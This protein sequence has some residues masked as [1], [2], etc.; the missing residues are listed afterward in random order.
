MR[1]LAVVLLV[2]AC[3]GK[4]AAPAQAPKTAPPAAATQ[5]AATQAITEDEARD[6]ARELS[7]VALPCNAVTMADQFGDN[8][9]AGRLLC[10]W[11]GG[12]S[13]Y[14]LVGVR[15]VDGVPHPIMRRLLTNAD[16][17][18]MFVNYD[19]L[20]LTRGDDGALHLADVFSYRQGVWIS[21]LL[22]ANAA[23][24]PGNADFLGPSAVHPEVKAARDLLRA[25]ERSGA[26]AAIAALPE[27]V[28][29]ERPVQMLRVRAAAG[30]PAAYKA[31]LDALGTVDDPAIALT[32]LDG[33]LDRGDG[34][35]AT[36]WIDVLEK[37]IGV[38]AYLE[39]QRVVALV[40]MG[41][42]DR[43]LTTATAAVELE[44]TLTRALEIKLDVLIAKKMWP[45]VLATMQKLEAEHDFEFD[46]AKLRAEP[47][48]AEFVNLPAFKEWAATR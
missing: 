30:N 19:E 10:D 8:A 15:S 2:A 12:V 33:A 35:A 24:T 16:S 38:E 13:S 5:A 41:D 9:T 18:A 43:A 29:A 11:L 1:L 3:K 21:E 26:L 40:R 37:T 32:E 17:G 14:T 27:A 39:S 28:R 34:P 36:K 22:E 44:P 46:L 25:G 20:A 6:Y 48:L 31:A 7:T 42:L 47:R 45:E 4:E 23:T